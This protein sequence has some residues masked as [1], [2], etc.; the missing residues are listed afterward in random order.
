M[1]KSKAWDME[2]HWLRDKK[3]AKLVKV[4]WDKGTNNGADYFTKHHATSHHQHIRQQRKYVRDTHTDLKHKI[5]S[6][7]SKM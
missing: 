7:F 3:I 5:N 1:K 2:L 4:F 6:I